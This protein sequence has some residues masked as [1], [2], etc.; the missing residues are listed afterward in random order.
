[1]KAKA[2]PELQMWLMLSLMPIGQVRTEVADISAPGRD[3]LKAD[4]MG[5]SPGLFYVRP[6]RASMDMVDLITSRLLARPSANPNI[7][8]NEVPPS[9]FLRNPSPP[10]PDADGLKPGF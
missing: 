2:P 9:A 5:L 7:I 4:M 6:T 10:I 3:A 8:F 1:M